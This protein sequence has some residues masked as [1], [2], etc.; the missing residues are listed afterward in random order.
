M[1]PQAVPFILR[2]FLTSIINGNG[3]KGK[4]KSGRSAAEF[5]LAGSPAARMERSCSALYKNLLQ[6]KKRTH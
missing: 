3:E 6:T 4:R 5:V 2:Q 1:D